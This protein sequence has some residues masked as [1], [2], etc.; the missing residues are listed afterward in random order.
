MTASG[1]IDDY[2]ADV[3]AS[4]VA[5]F[6]EAAG[7]DTSRVSLEVIAAS[8]HLVVSIE[9]DSESAAKAAESSLAPSLASAGAAAALM[10]AGVTVEST[11]M[12]AVTPALAPGQTWSPPPP[13]SL[14]GDG[15]L[16][17]GPLN[18]AGVGGIVIAGLVVLLAVV[19]GVIF[20][21][22]AKAPAWRNIRKSRVLLG[23]ELFHEGQLSSRN[24]PASPSS[25]GAPSY[26]P[27]VIS[28][29]GRPPAAPQPEDVRRQGSDGILALTRQQSQDSPR[30]SSRSD[31][32][33]FV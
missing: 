4:I 28:D 1:T 20:R 6:A 32:S 33:Q 26:A 19:A 31:L 12:L 8:V 30:T 5:N 23:S 9:S 7:V 18:S 10:P 2:T 27:N 15:D 11:P 16:S 17:S 13:G 3:R 25:P 21:R 14:S 24:A 29:T 22:K